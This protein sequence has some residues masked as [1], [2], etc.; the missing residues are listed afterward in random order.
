MMVDVVVIIEAIIG[1]ELDKN[2]AFAFNVA[3]A[4][5]IDKI[6]FQKDYNDI[7]NKLQVIK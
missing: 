7:K 1:L 5:I 4:F 3:R 6:L 2:E